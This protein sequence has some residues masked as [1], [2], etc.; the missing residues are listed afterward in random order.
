MDFDEERTARKKQQDKHIYIHGRTDGQTS[1]QVLTCERG[2]TES[3]EE[4]TACNVRIRLQRL[5]PK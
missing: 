3:S 5:S 2:R 4:Q 1:K